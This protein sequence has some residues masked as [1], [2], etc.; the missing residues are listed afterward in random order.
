MGGLAVLVI[1]ILD[2]VYIRRHQPPGDPQNWD[3][4]SHDGN[5]LDN[6]SG[7]GGREHP[8][9]NTNEEPYYELVGMN[10]R[11]SF[12]VPGIRYEQTS[13]G[14]L[15]D[16]QRPYSGNLSDEYWTPSGR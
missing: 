8:R 16:Q 13:F 6:R 5:N 4:D 11:D 14:N 1:G 2:V 7:R 15:R 10:R 12:E 9:P 3:D